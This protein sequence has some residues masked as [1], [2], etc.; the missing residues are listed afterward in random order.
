MRTSSDRA[1][2]PPACLISSPNPSLPND[3]CQLGLFLGSYPLI[4]CH[5]G[6]SKHHFHRLLQWLKI[7]NCPS[8]LAL[9]VPEQFECRPAQGV[10][11]TL[12]TSQYIMCLANPAQLTNPASEWAPPCNHGLL[13]LIFTPHVLP[14]QHAFAFPLVMI[15]SMAELLPQEIINPLL[16]ARVSS[17][18]QC[19]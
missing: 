18:I 3:P 16:F 2:C 6:C 4:G 12:Q 13:S 5:R 1:P 8:P 17:F 19:L 10:H 11:P 14:H 7:P 15:S 9:V